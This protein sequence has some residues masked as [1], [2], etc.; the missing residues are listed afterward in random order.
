MTSTNRVRQ[1]GDQYVA[2]THSP[3]EDVHSTVRA[4]YAGA[5]LV[6]TSKVHSGR[7]VSVYRFGSES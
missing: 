1:Y 5:H 7:Q 2:I 6:H 4:Q 3:S